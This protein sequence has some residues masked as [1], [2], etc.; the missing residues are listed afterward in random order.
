MLR[1]ILPVLR[2][3]AAYGWAYTVNCAWVTNTRI[4]YYCGCGLCNWG[5]CEAEHIYCLKI[6]L[7][8]T[9]ASWKCSLNHP[10]PPPKLTQY[11][12]TLSKWS[13]FLSA[14]KIFSW[15]PPNS[16]GPAQF[17]SKL[18]TQTS[19]DMCR[20]H[21]SKTGTF[22]LPPSLAQPLTCF[23]VSSSTHWSVMGS[24][25]LDSS[26]HWP[27]TNFA[28][29]LW[30]MW[31]TQTISTCYLMWK[32]AQLPACHHPCPCYSPVLPPLLVSSCYGALSLGTTL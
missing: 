19:S 30:L 2:R 25:T 26:L 7:C 12:I 20:V 27:W 14:M 29:I 4:L 16:T 32:G 10:L 23:T 24:S 21:I 5:L 22:Q 17:Y 11:S 28:L 15:W 8:P 31:L 3:E 13:T 1:L 6:H 9:W 18:C